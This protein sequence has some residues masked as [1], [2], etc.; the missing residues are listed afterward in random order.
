ML[1]EAIYDITPHEASLI[2]S[3]RASINFLQECLFLRSGCPNPHI[4]L[5]DVFKHTA[6]RT[7]LDIETE[8]PIISAYLELMKQ[9]RTEMLQ[10]LISS[11][12]DKLLQLV[13]PEPNQSFDPERL[14]VRSGFKKSFCEGFPDWARFEGQPEDL[15][16]SWRQ[17]VTRLKEFVTQRSYAEAFQNTDSRYSPEWHIS[18]QLPSGP[19]FREGSMSI[20]G[21]D[22]FYD[23]SFHLRKA[24]LNGCLSWEWNRDS[25]WICLLSFDLIARLGE[26]LYN[27]RDLSLLQSSIRDGELQ[28]ITLI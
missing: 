3:W 28:P 6:N 5:S 8:S 27:R 19:V 17:Y 2:L 20:D 23:A 10:S 11:G 22:I 4:K 9:M 16:M 7:P 26:F 18:G 13:R 12:V 1:E 14:T 21:V 25:F 24:S 15:V